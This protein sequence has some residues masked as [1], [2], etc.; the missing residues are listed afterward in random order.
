MSLFIAGYVF[1]RMGSYAPTL[2]VAS[3]LL[4]AA[5][6]IAWL[7]PERKCY[8]ESAGPSTGQTLATNAGIAR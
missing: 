1:D 4:V 5:S 3:I 8:T 6:I 7:S 2:A